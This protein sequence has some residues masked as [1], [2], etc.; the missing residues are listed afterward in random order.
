MAIIKR[1][2]N[3]CGEDAEEETL[4]HCCWFETAATTMENIMEIPLK[5][6][7]I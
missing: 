5:T 2:N 4:V 7:K 6:L 1:K 3:K